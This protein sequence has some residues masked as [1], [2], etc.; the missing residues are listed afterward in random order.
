MISITMVQFSKP[1]GF[2]LVVIGIPP[3]QIL[4]SKA[5]H[6]ALL[7]CD[8][9]PFEQQW[10][11]GKASGQQE[12]HSREAESLGGLPGD[13]CSESIDCKS[14]TPSPANYAAF[15]KDFRLLWRST[16]NLGQGQAVGDLE[17]SLF[18]Q[19]LKAREDSEWTIA[20]I[21]VS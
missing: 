12:R 2:G 17:L 15:Y 4:N 5:L 8:R 13:F 21:S 20:A 14:I 9:A 3:M 1:G 11:I 18:G 10:G 6:C 7:L 19:I 16:G